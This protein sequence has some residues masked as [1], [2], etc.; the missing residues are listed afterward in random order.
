[1]KRMGNFRKGAASF[2]IVAFSTL[3]LVVLAASFAM[4]VIAEVA[5][6]SNDELSQSAYDSAMAGIEDAKLAY[7]NYLRCI[8]NG[9]VAAAPN[10]DGQVSCGE[11]VYWMRNP[12]CYMVGHILGRIRDNETGEVVIGDAVSTSASVT[13][14]AYTCAKIN[15]TLADYRS[16]LSSSSQ[17]RVIRAHFEGGITA[18]SI[19]SVR[20]SWYSIRPD[21][22]LNYS[23]IADISGWRPVFRTAYDASV[24]VP[25]T[26]ELRLVQ[27]A[28]SFSISDFSTTSGGNTDRATAFLVPAG[29]VDAATISGSDY[30]Y[31]AWNGSANKIS[32]SELANT[33]T[34]SQPS[35][36]PFVVYCPAAGTGEF[37]CSVTMDLPNPVNG[38]R[39]NDTFM[40][41]VALPYG[42]PDTDFAVEFLCADGA[43]CSTM[44]VAGSEVNTN[45]A[46]ITDSQVSIDSTGRANDL[47]RRV[48]TRFETMDTSFPFPYYAIQVLGS[49]SGSNAPLKKKITSLKEYNFYR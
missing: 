6:T 48:E 29:N 22:S 17:I 15:T 37:A 11:I 20:F 33:N 8:K 31:G 42:Q 7:S 49:G 9:A 1:M 27:T 28:N 13:N 44:T 14:Q 23:N 47:Y 30:G 39:N 40:L 16:T 38:S 21:V 2:Y 4:T 10:G 43:T 36:K 32:A 41:V 19:K 26:V 5:K 45:Q 46:N 18:D 3:I 12:D 25:P 34:Q 35:N 24:A